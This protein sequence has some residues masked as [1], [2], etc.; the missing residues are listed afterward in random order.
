MT[1]TPVHPTTSNVV[2]IILA[3]GRSSRMGAFKPLLPFGDSTVIDCCINQLRAGGVE[4]VILV[5]GHRGDEL[6]E[7]LR[8]AKIIF[9]ENPDPE[10][11]MSSSIECAVKAVSQNQ[12]ALVIT[13]ADYPASPATVT[14]ELL[15]EWRSGALLVKPTW[16]SR[17]GHPVLIDMSFREQLFHL[18]PSRG[19][20][21]FFEEHLDQVKRVAVDSNYIARDLDT[22]DDYAALHQEVFG[23]PAPARIAPEKPR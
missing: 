18:N 9:V 13:P 17:G 2:G 16:N 10:G 12:G 8:D 20:K 6:R 23:Q 4:A 11:A 7:H 22:W 5:I 21:G 19:L 3:A 1:S 14:S 15:G